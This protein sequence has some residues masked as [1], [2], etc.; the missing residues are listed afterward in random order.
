MMIGYHQITSY[1]SSLSSELE[2]SELE[3]EE[4]E[5]EESL[6]GGGFDFSFALY[7]AMAW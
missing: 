2:S 5:L 6:G 3:S 1:S 4:L 7:S